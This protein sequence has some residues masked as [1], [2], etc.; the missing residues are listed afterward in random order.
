MEGVLCDVVKQG[1]RDGARVETQV[2]QDGGD[3][4]WMDDVGLAGLPFLP[5]VGRVSK[6]VRSLD[7]LR[8]LGRIAFR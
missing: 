6:L 5:H 1:C 7:E 8:V 4:L 3:R 2:S